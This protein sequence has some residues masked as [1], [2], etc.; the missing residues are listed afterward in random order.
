MR[1]NVIQVMK[2][3]SQRVSRAS[4]AGVLTDGSLKPSQSQAFTED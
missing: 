3:R 1:P 4:V 2:L